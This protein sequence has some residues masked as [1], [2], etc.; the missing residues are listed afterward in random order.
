MA[1]TRKQKYNH[2]NPIAR[3][4]NEKRKYKLR[5]ENPKKV[6]PVDEVSI[7]EATRIMKEENDE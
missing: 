6:P 4:L 2:R 1:K 7:H 5:V 3:E